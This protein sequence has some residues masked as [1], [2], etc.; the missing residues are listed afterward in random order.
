[1]A[2]AGPEGYYKID[3]SPAP[4]TQRHLKNICQE[5]SSA[6]RILLMKHF[7]DALLYSVSMSAV[8][9]PEIN[10]DDLF[11]APVPK[12]GHGQCQHMELLWK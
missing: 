12:L 4:R 8:R 2:E 6:S 1:M 3:I 5:P 9:D 11:L 7:E 10:K